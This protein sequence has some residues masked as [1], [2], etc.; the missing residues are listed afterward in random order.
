MEQFGDI[1]DR[2]MTIE[3]E[4]RTLELRRLMKK[5]EARA[6]DNVPDTRDNGPAEDYFIE[7]WAIV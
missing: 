4:D 6:W 5:L 3:N 7:K 1:P 2:R